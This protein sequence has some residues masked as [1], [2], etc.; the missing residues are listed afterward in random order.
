MNAP[1]NPPFAFRGPFGRNTVEMATSVRT[2]PLDGVPG[3]IAN[4]IPISQLP[5]AGSLDGS[6]QV[7]IVQNGIT[8]RTPVF[9]LAGP[10]GVQG[11]QGA[12]GPTGPTGPQGIIADPPSDN[13]YYSRRNADWQVS[14]GGLTDA[15]NDGTLYARKSAAW[16]HVTHNDITD[17][18]A[19]VPAAYVLPQATTAV[20]G[21]VTVD[22]STIS[23]ASGKISAINTAA[24]VYLPIAGGTLTGPLFGTGAT[25]SGGQIAINGSPGFAKFISG[26]SGGTSR[27]DLMLGDNTAESGANAG[28]NLV[29]KSY[30]DAGGALATPLTIN[31][32][33]GVVAIPNLSAPQ[34]IGDNRLINGDMRIDQR[35]GGAATTAGGYFIDRWACN[36]SP[37]GKLSMGRNLSGA[38]GPAGFPYCIGFQTTTAY[39]SPAAGDFFQLYQPVEADMIGDFAWGSANAQPITLSFWAY[40]SIAGTYSGGVR[41]YLGT[42]SYPFTFALTAG[43]WTRVVITI[44]GD[45]VGT[46]VMSGNGGSLLL[47]FDL[48]CGANNRGPAGAWTGAGGYIGV[49]GAASLVATLNAQLFVTGVKLEIGSVA[50]PFN[51]QSLAKSMADCQRYYAGTAV[52]AVGTAPG[53][54]WYLSDT[55]FFPVTMRTTPTVTSSV[56]T[57]DANVTAFNLDNGT[58]YSARAYAYSAGVGTISFDRAVQLSAEL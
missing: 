5:L 54:N 44:P 19:N 45:T 24:G 2:T 42:R 17:W 22:G 47:S 16:A 39:P 58:P 30:T 38:T 40:A 43:V 8:T 29:V 48:G 52:H 10:Q 23:V 12:S 50:T 13:Q 49:T 57:A 37:A 33:S 9:N 14:P 31:R 36:M 3:P 35:N 56:M 55:V 1:V 27:W 7:P 6:E 41:N 21:G 25:F 26:W 32:A 53:S 46:W 20:L 34:A 4:E 28:T 15:A 11:P 18:N 51:R